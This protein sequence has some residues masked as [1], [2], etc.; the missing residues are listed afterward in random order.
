MPPAA[1][2]AGA[3]RGDLEAAANDM[4]AES[5]VIAPRGQSAGT[6]HQ[7]V[8]RDGARVRI[9]QSTAADGARVARLYGRMSPDPLFHRFVA[10]MQP[11]VDWDRLAARDDAHRRYMLL[12]E[13]VGA[14][15]PDVVAVASCQGT[16]TAEISEVALLVRHD[17]QDRG[18]GTILFEAL[19]DAGAALGIRRFRA[20]VLADNHRMLDMLERCGAVESRSC[21]SGVI[22]VVFTRPA[23]RASADAAEGSRDVL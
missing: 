2:A 22:D 11:L 1:G 6:G 23:V 9:R 21:G 12:A 15:P 20:L 3:G 19:L 14:D 16:P 13:D 4:A 17:W 8:L 7:V 18:V 10:L 5:A